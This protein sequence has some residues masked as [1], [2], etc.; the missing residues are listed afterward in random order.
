MRED[1]SLASIESSA[2]VLLAES[3]VEV[4][5]GERSCCCPSRPSVRVVLPATACRDHPVDLLLCAHHYR[6]SAATLTREGA[7]VFDV[8]GV[9]VRAGDDP[10]GDRIPP[11][12]GIC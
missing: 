6:H 4:R 12:R 5:A 7:H 11:L 10:A 2:G 8:S 9:R 1:G 3:P